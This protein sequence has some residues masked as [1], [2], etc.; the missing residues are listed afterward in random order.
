MLKVEALM[1]SKKI[2]LDQGQIWRNIEHNEEHVDVC[3]TVFP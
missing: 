2:N 3:H 1:Y